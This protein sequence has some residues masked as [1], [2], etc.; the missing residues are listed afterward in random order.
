M[1]RF[2]SDRLRTQATL[3]AAR[4]QLKWFDIRHDVFV[5]IAESVG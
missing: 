2:R 5:S 4:A 3:E 1:D